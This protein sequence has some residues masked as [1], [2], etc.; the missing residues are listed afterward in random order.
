M[1]PFDDYVQA[2]ELEYDSYGDPSEYSSPFDD[3]EDEDHDYDLDD[4]TYD[5]VISFVF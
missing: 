5:E 3:Y 2:D 4:Q 1:D